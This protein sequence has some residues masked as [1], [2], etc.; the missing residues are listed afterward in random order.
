MKSIFMLL[1][2]VGL[3]AGCEQSVR[4]DTEPEPEALK[5]TGVVYSFGTASFMR[6]HIDGVDCVIAR[7]W[8]AVAASCDWGSKHN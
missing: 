2:V 3:V 5:A 1:L 7:R 8:E 4:D 6:T